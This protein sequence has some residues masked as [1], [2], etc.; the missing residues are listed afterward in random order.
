VSDLLTHV[1]VAFVVATVASWSLP[2]FTRRHVPLATAGAVAPDL[3]KGSLVTGDAQVTVAGVI[4]SWHALQTVGVVTCLVV[5]GAMLVERAERPAAL[6]ALLGGTGL[7]VSMDYLVVRA[8]GVA[9]PYLYPLTWA[10]LPSF[11][12]Y[13]S[14]SLWPSLVALPV[15]T[16]VWF[17]DR[18]GLA[19][20]SDSTSSGTTE[21]ADGDRA[22]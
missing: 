1:L 2:W 12:V 22:N 9:P 14:S 10:E 17:V 19:P 6:A 3:A 20:G 16:L 13:L 7:H 4:G 15:A 11:D 21:P 18:R 5:A 8:G